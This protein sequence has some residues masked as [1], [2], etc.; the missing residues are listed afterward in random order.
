VPPDDLSRRAFLAASGGLVVAA[1]TFPELAIAHED[2]PKGPWGTLVLS[3]DLYA[4][5]TPQRF[6][7]AMAKG[8]RR[9]SNGRTRVGFV[10]PSAQSRQATIELVPAHLYRT[11]LPK[12]RGVFV[13]DT[14][15]DEPGVW[16][17]VARTHGENVP[18]ALDVKPAAEAPVVGAAAPRAASPTKADRLSVK[19]IC[20]RHPPCPLHTVSLAEV[21][22]AGTP[23][24]VLFATPARCQS[25]YCG[26]VLDELLDVRERYD[27]VTFA[28]V[29]IY[30]NNETTSL[31]PTVEAWGLPSEPWLYT[32]DAAG[33]I[34]GRIDGAFGRQEIVSQLDP[35]VG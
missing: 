4:S 22:G 1:M 16:Q 33:T 5:P 20:T 6:V 31:A 23:V 18:F 27:G 13:V 9:S 10:P 17:A 11:G 26:P 30:L 12:G 25:E 24:A 29:E 14:V 2:E 15:F 32:I 35:L 21:V 28:H 7:F 34:V 8:R 3:S 19:P